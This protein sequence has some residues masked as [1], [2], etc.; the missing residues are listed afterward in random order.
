MSAT[1]TVSIPAEIHS[2]AVDASGK[3]EATFVLTNSSTR[4]VQGRASVV[5]QDPA[6][7]DW[8]RIIGSAERSFR[9]GEAHQ[10]K[11]EVSLPAE[12]PAGTYR[13]R[14]D[15]L[16]VANPDED[17]AEGQTLTFDWKPVALAPKPARPSWFVPAIIA[18]CVALLLGLGLVFLLRDTTVA[19]PDVLGKTRMEAESALKAAGLQPSETP[20]F[21]FD[22]SKDLNVVLGLNSMQAG[23]ANKLDPGAILKKGSEVALTVNKFGTI[24]EKIVGKNV[25]E[26]I[27][28]LTDSGVTVAVPIEEK[29][30]KNVPAGIV[31]SIEPPSGRI[32]WDRKVK[33]SAN[34]GAISVANVIV[35]GD[36][37]NI[38]CTLVLTYRLPNG[39]SGTVKSKEFGIKQSASVE[40]PARAKG[41]SLQIKSELT[42]GI[43][44]RRPS[45]DVRFHVYKTLNFNPTATFDG[46]VH[47]SFEV[48]GIAA[49]A[50]FV[51]WDLAPEG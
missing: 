50:G 38:L 18:A 45:G 39:E 40:I 12:T 8:F 32:A 43:T 24:P 36:D 11:V 5:P 34:R 14:L 46:P 30:E 31:F 2:L 4:A 35:T 17:V 9:G 21:D 48:R 23:K 33:L 51:A 42:K 10:Y 27:K 6:R 44:E 29:L 7:R 47:K 25:E 3:G 41:V 28:E 49:Q 37:T 22:P 20:I 16:N 19:V 13:F 26:A 1:L 15:A